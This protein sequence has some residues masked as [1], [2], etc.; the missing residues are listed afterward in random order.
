MAR[1]QKQATPRKESSQSRFN[2]T[3]K[4]SPK[5]NLT[6][7]VL[8]EFKRGRGRPRKVNSSSKQV[9]VISDAHKP[10][11][12]NDSVTSKLRKTTRDSAKLLANGNLPIE[13][14]ISETV[15][16]VKKDTPV[17]T[18]L[19]Y[20]NHNSDD[21]GMFIDEDQNSEC[22]T[23]PLT[24]EYSAT[25]SECDRSESL[26]DG[27][28]QT[29]T[30]K[31]SKNLHLVLR[32]LVTTI[33]NQRAEISRLKKERDLLNRQLFSLKRPPSNYI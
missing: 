10:S 8:E 25:G 33:E 24:E 14:E 32:K 4:P 29:T 21:V 1:R 7:P 19:P 28:S 2:K 23:L 18:V 20:K 6:T 12:S 13:K 11:E 31:I 27:A 30:I 5:T 17:T 9:T 16:S 3:K 15:T 22:A 26:I